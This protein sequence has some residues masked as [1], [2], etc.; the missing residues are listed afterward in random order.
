MPTSRYVYVADSQ[1]E[2]AGEGLWV[3]TDIRV[4]FHLQHNFHLLLASDNLYLFVVKWFCQAGQ[5]AAVFNGL[6][7]RDLPGVKS[8]V[9]TWSDYRIRWAWTLKEDSWLRS[10]QL[11]QGDRPG[12]WQGG[13]E[14]VQLQSNPR[15]QVLPLL[16]AKRSLCTILA[17]NVSDHCLLI[18]YIV[19]TIFTRYGLVMSIVASRDLV[20]G[21]EIFVSYNYALEKA[22]EWYQVSMRI[23]KLL[24]NRKKK[25]FFYLP[26]HR[27]GNRWACEFRNCFKIGR[28]RYFLPT[29]AGDLVCS[30]KRKKYF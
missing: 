6:R 19:S 26:L 28:K 23:S 1:T 21:E 15:A 22:P 12:H 4:G 10:V 24:L 25:T 30:P 13:G 9:K 17:S 8:G 16:Q 14:L 27:S 29:F 7:Q 2:G 3:K 11:Q 18:T 20:P 5:I